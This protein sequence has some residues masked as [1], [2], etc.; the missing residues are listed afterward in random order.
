MAEIVGTFASA[1][2]LATLFKSCIQAFDLI[3]TSQ[4]QATDLKKLTLRLNIEK[5]RL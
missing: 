5:C 1:V 4:N 2:T 3:H